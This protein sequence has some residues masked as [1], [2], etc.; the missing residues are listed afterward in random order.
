MCDAETTRSEAES[1]EITLSASDQESGPGRYIAGYLGLNVVIYI[2][3]TIYIIVNFIIS[4]KSIKFLD[5]N[6][7]I[8]NI[9]LF[10]IIAMIA[11]FIL[12]LMIAVTLPRDGWRGWVR[13]LCVLLFHCFPFF[14]FLEQCSHSMFTASLEDSEEHSTVL[15]SFII[16]VIISAPFVGCGL[17]VEHGVSW[18]PW[19]RR[20]A[21]PETSV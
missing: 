5:I 18:R 14:I 7:F 17:L 2:F 16:S 19:R 10:Y 11:P 4:G 12:S 9:L 15:Q 20:K 13:S 21:P 6:L 1:A 3:I 8:L